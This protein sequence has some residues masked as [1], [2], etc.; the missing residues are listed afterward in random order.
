MA[1]PLQDGPTLAL[2]LG[3]VKYN[4]V[5]FLWLMSARPHRASVR[6][7][8]H[9]MWGSGGVRHHAIAAV[10]LGAIERLVGA[11]EHIGR[12]IIRLPER[13]ETDRDRHLH[14]ALAFADRE[15]LRRDAPAQA[16]RHH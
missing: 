9:R 8:T 5:K 2:D 6:F 16:L 15:G 7:A 11:L 10:A 12:G 4:I 3:F 1:D 14:A 13:G